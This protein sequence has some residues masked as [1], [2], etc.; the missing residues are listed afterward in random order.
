MFVG[1]TVAKS[2]HGKINLVV[3]G[4]IR[5]GV[6]HLNKCYLNTDTGKKINK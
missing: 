6:L 3:S 4:Q 2:E 5:E 1:N